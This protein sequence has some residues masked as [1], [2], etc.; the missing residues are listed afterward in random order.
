M[1]PV[2][3]KNVGYSRFFSVKHLVKSPNQPG[4]DKLIEV[5]FN[6]QEEL[7]TIEKKMSKQKLPCFFVHK[8]GNADPKPKMIITEKVLSFLR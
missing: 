7:V 5:T 2:L 1:A 4:R 6:S 3:V 8:P